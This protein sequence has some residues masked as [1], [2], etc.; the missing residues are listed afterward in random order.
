[1]KISINRY[2]YPYS[3]SLKEQ[4]AE[5][6]KKMIIDV[7]KLKKTIRKTA[8]ELKLSHPALIKK[9]QKYEIKVDKIVTTGNI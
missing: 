4:V 5:F 6:E 8:S 9:M 1:D 3:S 2:S 7:L